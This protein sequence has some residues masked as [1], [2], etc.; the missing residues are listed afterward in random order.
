MRILQ[1]PHTPAAVLLG[2]IAALHAVIGGGG[3]VPGAPARS[4]PATQAA[5]AH[6]V[7]LPPAGSAARKNLDW[8][9]HNVEIVHD[10]Y[11]AS[12]CSVLA[13]EQRSRGRDC[14]QAA[15]G[16]TAQARCEAVLQAADGSPECT[17]PDDRAQLLNLARSRAEQQCFDEA[18]MRARVSR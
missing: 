16:A 4:P 7:Q 12:A 11:W 17:L 18:A 13:D 14:L 15:H 10:V 2:G 5:T 9:R 8:C 1:H 3:G 6:T